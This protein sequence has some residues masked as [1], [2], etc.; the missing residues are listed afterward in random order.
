MKERWHIIPKG[1][2][3]YVMAAGE[4]G[5]FYPVHKSVANEYNHVLSFTTKEGAMGYILKHFDLEQYEPELYWI[6]EED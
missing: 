6:I 2:G 1:S 5:T 4:G 3:Y